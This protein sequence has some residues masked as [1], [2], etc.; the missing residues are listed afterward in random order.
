MFYTIY[1]IY[2][3]FCFF[4]CYSDWDLNPILFEMYYKQRSIWYVNIPVE[5]QESIR[6]Y[7]KNGLTRNPDRDIDP[8]LDNTIGGFGFAMMCECRFVSEDGLTYKGGPGEFVEETT[9][10]RK[11]IKFPFFEEGKFDTL[12]TFV[13]SEKIYTPLI[14]L[15]I[16][17]VGILD[18]FV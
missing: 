8:L 15:Y 4:T 2:K 12:V 7:I 6:R 16:L 14:F 5:Y 17:F 1:Y 18:F 3:K 10:D 13:H 9:G 11:D